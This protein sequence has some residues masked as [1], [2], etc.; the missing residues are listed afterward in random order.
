MNKFSPNLD[1]RFM[2]L[3]VL[4]PYLLKPNIFWTLKSFDQTFLGPKNHLD[5]T[6]LSQPQPQ[7][8]V[9]QPQ[10]RGW[11]GHEND[12]AYTPPPHRNSTAA[13]VSLRTTLIDD[14]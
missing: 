1:I 5:G 3:Y 11:V 9:T 8:N 12:F 13:S 7:H 6:F 4:D 14:N 10:H 2:V